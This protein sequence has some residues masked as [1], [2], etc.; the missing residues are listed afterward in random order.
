MFFSA[1]S[2]AQQ[3]VKQKRNI[4]LK[5]NSIPKK[6]EQNVSFNI[7]KRQAVCNVGIPNIS[8]KAIKSEDSNSQKVTDNL[9]FSHKPENDGTVN[10]Q[11]A[12]DAWVLNYPNE[13]DAWVKSNSNVVGKSDETELNTRTKENRRSP[14]SNPNRHNTKKHE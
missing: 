10:Y 2:F 12:K 5:T 8:K 7:S 14:S 3:K 13:Y 6:A 4:G 11:K 9:L 1:A